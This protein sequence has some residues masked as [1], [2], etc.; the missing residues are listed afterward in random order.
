[1]ASSDPTGDDANTKRLLSARSKWVTHVEFLK[2]V[3]DCRNDKNTNRLR[4]LLN[5]A[6][7]EKLRSLASL[8][9][10]FLVGDVDVP[11]EIE[12]KIIASKKLNLLK[13]S[14]ELERSLRATVAGGRDKLLPAYYSVLSVIPLIVSLV[15]DPSGATAAEAAATDAT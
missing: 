8:I 2:Q 4:H 13:E 10:H 15:F 11:S 6:S 3:R 5:L 9:H 7:T 14:F 12:R 1:M